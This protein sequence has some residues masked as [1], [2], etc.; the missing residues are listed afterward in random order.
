MKASKTPW[1]IGLALLALAALHACAVTGVDV[2]GSVGVG[3]D[4]G[5]YEPGGYA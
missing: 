4:A 3:Y 2:G 1:L 5:Y